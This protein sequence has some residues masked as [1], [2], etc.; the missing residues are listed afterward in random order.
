MLNYRFNPNV[1]LLSDAGAHFQILAS[2]PTSLVLGYL[3]IVGR[4]IF[5]AAG[6]LGRVLEV[7]MR[8]ATRASMSTDP[9]DPW[10][11][12]DYT[13]SMDS[14]ALNGLEHRIAD[15][16]RRIRTDLDG[17]STT[18]IRALLAHGESHVYHYLL[19]QHANAFGPVLS[20][21][22]AQVPAI[23]ETL[24]SWSESDCRHLKYSCVNSAFMR[25]L[26]R[27]IGTLRQRLTGGTPA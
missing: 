23:D 13:I 27:T 12:H 16:V 22:G 17:F 10:K 21:T 3:P 6:V 9:N 7:M 25:A 26:Y 11:V 24:N 8:R 18:E 14:P 1:V 5:G 2:P 4:L 20:V 19:L 15:Y